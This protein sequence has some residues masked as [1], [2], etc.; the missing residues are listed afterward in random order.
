MT[1]TLET[2]LRNAMNDAVQNVFLPA[3]LAQDIIQR[4]GQRRQTYRRPRY[5]I[6]TLAACI[7]LGIALFGA[8][9]TGRSPDQAWAASIES[10]QNLQPSRQRIAVVV[11]GI[12]LT[13]LP[14][15]VREPTGPP[16]NYPTAGPGYSL[17]EQGFT[18]DGRIT[19][20]G[21]ESS[22]GERSFSVGV[23]RGPRAE[24]GHIRQT[25][26]MGDTREASFAG[27]RALRSTIE[28]DGGARSLYWQIAP[29]VVASVGS[30]GLTDDE[31]V[32]IAAGMRV[33]D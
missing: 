4:P 29:G 2:Q 18:T 8:E 7:A 1:I 14:E 28:S 23:F 15:G 3:G 5:A 22:P 30:L 9:V 31:V 24:L 33:V 17:E 12:G 21:I 27:Q 32:A 20:Q 19:P 26:F 6:A 13:Y 16:S 25:M 11:S 10:V